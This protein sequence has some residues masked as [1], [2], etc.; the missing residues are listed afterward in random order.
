MLIQ[1]HFIGEAE[2]LEKQNRQTTRTQREGMTGVRQRSQEK[3]APVQKPRQK[4]GIKLKGG[5]RGDVVTATWARLQMVKLAT[6]NLATPSQWKDLG[7]KRIADALINPSSCCTNT[8][9]CTHIHPVS[10]SAGQAVIK[11]ALT[12]LC[13]RCYKVCFA[14]HPQSKW[15]QIYF[16]AGHW[17]VPPDQKIKLIHVHE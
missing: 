2:Q 9:K 16:Q 12:L 1:C 7:I 10:V 15:G 8:L 5:C 14:G 11:S 3:H 13:E 17:Q 4:H 6:T